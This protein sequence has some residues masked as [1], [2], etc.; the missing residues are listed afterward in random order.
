[1]S[2]GDCSL[3]ESDEGRGCCKA[4]VSEV[5]SRIASVGACCRAQNSSGDMIGAAYITDDLEA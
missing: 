1:M 2:I 3:S 4:D 5:T